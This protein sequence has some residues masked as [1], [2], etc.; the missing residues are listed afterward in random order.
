MVKLHSCGVFKE[1][2]EGRRESQQI[3]WDPSLSHLR[4]GII[5]Q[6]SIQ[7]SNK[8]TCVRGCVENIDKGSDISLLKI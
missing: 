6:A 2:F 5:Y 7:T 8:S 1:I 4:E 3:I